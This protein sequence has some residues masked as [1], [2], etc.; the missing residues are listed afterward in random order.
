MKEEE[1]EEEEEGG[2]GG[3]GMRKSKVK[4]VEYHEKIIFCIKT[5]LFLFRA[6]LEGVCFQ[7]RDIFEVTLE[8]NFVTKTLKYLSVHTFW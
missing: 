3:G 7:V 5:E 2:G 4:T 6:V 1:E 8:Y